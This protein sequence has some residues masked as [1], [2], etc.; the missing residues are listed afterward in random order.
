VR[1]ILLIIAVFFVGIILIAQLFSESKEIYA[2]KIEEVKEVN[3]HYSASIPI[4]KLDTQNSEIT[5]EVQ[6]SLKI[7]KNEG[8]QNQISEIELNDE[9][10]L[11]RINSVNQIPVLVPYKNL[12]IKRLRNSEFKSDMP[13]VDNDILLKKLRG[14]FVGTIVNINSNIVYEL[15]LENFLEFS[16]GQLRGRFEIEWLKNG[17]SFL[18]EEQLDTVFGPFQSHDE[19]WIR[20]NSGCYYQMIYL[21]K[22]DRFIGNYYYQFKHKGFFDLRR[23]K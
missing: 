18:T 17:V 5:D 10:E 13:L 1:K 9:I 7:E 22:E 20:I 23:R 6:S 11:E 16:G 12:L 3:K 19:I 15:K 2:P 4:K 14:S 8:E 21:E